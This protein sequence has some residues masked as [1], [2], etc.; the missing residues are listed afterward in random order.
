M[1]GEK[2]KSKPPRVAAIHP[3]LNPR[4]KHPY[5][6]S[7]LVT[8][9]AVSATFSEATGPKSQVTGASGT[10]RART[11]VLSS[12]LMPAGTCTRVVRKRLWPWLIA[13]AG[14]AKNHTND[15]GSPQ[16]HTMVEVG[17]PVHTCHHIATPAPR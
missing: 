17:C 5:A 14:Q 15:E 1:N 8:G 6:D 16:P 13:Y 3:N 12:R 11:L 7:A 9:A 2:P 4:R 10:P